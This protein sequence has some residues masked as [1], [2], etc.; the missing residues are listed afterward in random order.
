MHILYICRAFDNVAGGIEYSSTVFMNEM[1]RRGHNVSLVTWDKEGAKAFF[2]MDSKIN[3]Q[4]LNLGDPWKKAGISLRWRR[5]LKMRHLIKNIRPDVIVGFHDDC[6]VM[7]RIA[8]AGLKIPIIAAERNPPSR[9]DFS[10]NGT[11]K[12][13]LNQLFRT[14]RFVT[15]FFDRYH[16]QYPPY[17]RRKLITIPNMIY[18]VKTPANPRGEGVKPKILLFV[19]RLEYQKNPLVLVRAFAQIADQHPD[20]H[21]VLAGEGT[22]R[23]EIEK[24]ITERHLASRIKL[25]GAVKNIGA[26]YEQA[27]LFCFPS[28]WEGFG[29]ALAEALSY[30]LPCVGFAECC[31][32][33]D[34]IAHEKS[35]LLAPGI[36]DQ[37]ALAEAL[38]PL[39]ENPDLREKMGD[40]AR[41]SVAQY[42][43]HIIFD[44]WEETFKKAVQ[45]T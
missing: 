40:Y 23:A 2:P 7:A 41:K 35:G 10:L 13:F 25:L 14:S 34:L 43:P 29:N 26:L 4:M 37:A 42:E 33:R 9:F 15:V 19:G 39:M 16:P 32:V 11:K 38:G 21:L 36:D 3:W 18:P 5:I 12:A 30:G 27:H 8:S 44:R 20:W 17:L 28:R 24:I 1:V 22:D 31:G 6:F 45:T